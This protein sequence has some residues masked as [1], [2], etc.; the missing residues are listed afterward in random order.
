MHEDSAQIASAQIEREGSATEITQVYVHPD[1]QGGGRGT[2]LIR[3]AIE[4]AVT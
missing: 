4:A 1:H 3:A 2:A